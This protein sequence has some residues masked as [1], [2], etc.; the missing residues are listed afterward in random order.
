MDY[1]DDVLDRGNDVVLKFRSGAE[2]SVPPGSVV[3]NCTGYLR[4][5]ELRYQPYLSHAGRVLT[6]TIGRECSRSLL[7]AA[8]C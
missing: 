2:R 3:V 1:L 7:G 5:R 4:R 8:T 6:I